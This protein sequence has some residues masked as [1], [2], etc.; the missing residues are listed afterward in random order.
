MII[1]GSNLLHRSFWVAERS[2]NNTSNSVSFIFLKSL[3]TLIE[4]FKPSNT[5]VVWDKKI[6]SNS[7]N[8]RKRLLL[9]KYKATRDQDRNAKVIAH[10]E[11]IEKLLSSLGVKQIYPNTLEADDVISWLTKRVDERCTVVSVD[12]DLLQ[13]IT[14]NTQVYNPIKKQIINK[15]NFL[16]VIGV[17]L[18]DFLKYKALLGDESDNIEGVESYGAVKCKKACTDSIESIS[19]TLTKEQFEVFERNLKVI[20]LSNSYNIEVG[21]AEVYE[22]QF[23]N[24][25]KIKPDINLFSKLCEECGFN[26]IVKDIQTWKRCFVS[27]QKLND[28]IQSLNSV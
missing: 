21:E 9:D 14:N 17:E 25:N 8:F 2:M 24:V 3:R 27:S 15:D 7:L 16:S 23:N 28:L 5:W 26:S 20:D 6:T 19:L 1:D 10:H 11:I 4:K 13:L 12:K 18:K 22:N